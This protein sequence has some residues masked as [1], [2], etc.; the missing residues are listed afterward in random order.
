MINRVHGTED[1]LYFGYWII[2]AGFITQFVAVG[3]TNY[4]VGS[5]MIPMTE[6]FG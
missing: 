2:V 3:M 4:V 6:E 1:S 5:F